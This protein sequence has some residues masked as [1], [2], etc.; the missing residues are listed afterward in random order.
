MAVRM[1]GSA[2]EKGTIMDEIERWLQAL[3]L[4]LPFKCFGIIHLDV[5][6]VYWRLFNALTRQVLDSY[7][8]DFPS[9]LLTGVAVRFIIFSS[10]LRTCRCSRFPLWSNSPTPV[11][12]MHHP[13]STHGCVQAFQTVQAVRGSSRFQEL[14]LN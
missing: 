6:S 1:R 9:I 3:S 4:S 2:F 13:N 10:P 7:Q 14:A 12:G 11:A 5:H 8:W